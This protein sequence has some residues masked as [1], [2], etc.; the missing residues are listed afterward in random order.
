MDQE[1]L[2]AVQAFDLPEG[3]VQA[4]PHG[5][6]HIN[7]TYQ[8]TISGDS[9]RYILQWINQ[10]VFHYPDQVDRKSVV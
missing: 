6:G 3:E 1:I 10:H 2:R 4:E 9:G 8:V 5:N 7:R